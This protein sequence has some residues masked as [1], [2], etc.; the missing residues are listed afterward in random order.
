MTLLSK[1]CQDLVVVN[2]WV[3]FQKASHATQHLS[4]LVRAH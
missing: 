2:V 4:Q 1:V 3:R